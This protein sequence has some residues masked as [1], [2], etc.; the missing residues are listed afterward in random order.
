LEWTP[1][2]ARE[3]SNEDALLDRIHSPKKGK[4]KYKLGDWVRIH[5]LK[6]RFEKGFHGNFSYEIYQIVGIRKSEPVMYYL[7]DYFGELIDG[8]FYDNDLTSVADP[9]FFPIETVLDRRVYKRQ[10][11][12][13]VKYL[14]YKEPKWIA[15]KF[16][17]SL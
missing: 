6:G 16:V 5:R 14:G 4:P 15:D 2:D 11:Q 1:T 8:G 17:N 10:P 9:S 12:M 7:Q 3:P 13:L